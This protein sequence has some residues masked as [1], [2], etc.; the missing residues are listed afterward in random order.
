MKYDLI[1]AGAGIAGCC[2]AMKVA[3]S[4]CTVALL[5]ARS[6][7]KIGHP[8]E[9]TIDENVFGTAGIK[10]PDRELWEERPEYT[11]FY[12]KDIN[13][14]AKVH[15]DTFHNFTIRHEALNT[16]LLE[17]AIKS[18]V[19]FLGGHEIEDLIIDGN[20]VCGIRG[21]QNRFLVKRPFELRGKIIA[22]CTGVNACL[23]KKTPREFNIKHDVRIQDFA[24][25]WQE[26]HQL[27]NTPGTRFGSEVFF[28]PGVCFTRIGKYHAYTTVHM[29]RNNTVNL[30]FGTSVSES[31]PA[32]FLCKDYV[33]SAPNLGKRLGGGGAMIPLRRGLDNLVG[34]GFI[35]AGDSACQVIPTMGSGVASSL[36]A[37]SIAARTIVSAI[38]S[39]DVSRRSLWQYNA[40]YQGGL[41][42]ILASYDIIRR[43]IQSLSMDE[44]E[45]L[46]AAGLVN[47]NTF[48]KTYSTA[49]ISHHI[50]DVLDKI[51]RIFAHPGLLPVVLRFRQALDDSKKALFLYQEYP[52]QYDERVF[53]EWQEKTNQLFSKYR[54][55]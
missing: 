31:R 39:G 52:K 41:G 9:V 46:F 13:L 10:L 32:Y 53:I 12:A 47:D 19:H 23:R 25:A 3:Q 6:R 15:Y 43:F 45:R 50:G 33:K 2:C 21:V 5:D 30:I 48:V 16:L 22:D 36:T 1:V 7:N 24:S 4:G 38:N 28:Q 20:T 54:T 55:F 18:G 40:E 14:S 44:M 51:G 49:H 8:W 27:K 17:R 35:L 11:V 34:N 29:R 37:A 42:A 26:V